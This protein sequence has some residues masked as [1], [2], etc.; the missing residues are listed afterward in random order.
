MEEKI[1]VVD[2]EKS[3]A[4][5][6]AYAFRREG[7]AVETAYDGISALEKI[8]SFNPDLVILDVMMPNMNGFEVCKKLGGR[9]DM[10]II[11][12]TA[13]DDI[14]DK[15]LGLELGGD[16]YITK[17]FDIRE[18][19]ARSKSLLRRIQKASVKA[20]DDEILIEDLRLIPMQRR[21]MLDGERLDLKPKEFDLLALL[22][23]NLDRVYTREELLDIVWGIEYAGGTRT[24]DIH[25]QR[26]R[27]KLGP[28]Y[29]GMIQTVF[30]VGYK[31]AGDFY[32]D[33]H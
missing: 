5:V 1:L 10:G 9:E 28:K 2:D 12:V 14:V 30:G 24:V 20:S 13:K 27:K 22:L 33:E 7:Y 25:V 15:V 11:L 32:E 23:S 8:K 6:I 4:D 31:A 18:V 29:Q 19:I 21:V 26:L 3:I 16:D 17:P